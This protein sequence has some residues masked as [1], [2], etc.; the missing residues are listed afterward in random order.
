MSTY[1][2]Q[3]RLNDQL[4]KLPYSIIQ[5][6]AQFLDNPDDN[7]MNWKALISVMPDGAYTQQQV[8]GTFIQSFGFL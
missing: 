2:K 8:R 7:T 6:L 1:D 5:S 4:R 3:K